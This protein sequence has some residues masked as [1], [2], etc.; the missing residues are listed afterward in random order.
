MSPVRT[1][2][3]LVATQE[4]VCSSQLSNSEQTPVPCKAVP[5]RTILLLVYERAD[6]CGYSMLNF[7]KA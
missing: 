1:Y 2:N 3:C 4:E 7:G 5:S 6:N